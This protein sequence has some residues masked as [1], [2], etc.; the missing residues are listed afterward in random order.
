M[1]AKILTS[2]LQS[3]NLWQKV[4]YWRPVWAHTGPGKEHKNVAL[5]WFGC[6]YLG[7]NSKMNDPIL[8]VCSLSIASFILLLLNYINV[9]VC[10]GAVARS[11][12]GPY[13]TL[14]G[15]NLTPIFEKVQFWKKS[16]LKKMVYYV[17]PVRTSTTPIKKND[18]IPT[19]LSKWHPK[20]LVVNTN[21]CTDPCFR[22]WN[23][24]GA[25]NRKKYPLLLRKHKYRTT[26]IHSNVHYRS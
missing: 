16:K 19:V 1:G 10:F 5:I 2:P 7:V 9:F 26:N 13:G 22:S 25:T 8:Y 12:M 24:N 23:T 21:W 11:S 20:G 4:T 6:L 14:I 15:H 18:K 17:V 3:A